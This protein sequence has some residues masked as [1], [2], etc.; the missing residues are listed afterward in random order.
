M[1]T[2]HKWFSDQIQTSATFICGPESDIGPIFLLLKT[3]PAVEDV[4]GGALI[5][6]LNSSNLFKSSL[7][8]LQF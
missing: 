4:S 3:N 2:A 8:I 7:A 5:I 1:C 6:V